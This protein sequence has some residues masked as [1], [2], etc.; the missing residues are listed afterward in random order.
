MHPYLGLKHKHV[1]RTE[2]EEASPLH[3]QPSDWMHFLDRTTFYAGII[4]PF[5]VVPQIW[6]IFTTH[7]AAGVSAVSWALIFIVTL[8]WVFYGIA[9]KDKTIIVSFVLWEAVNALVV[10]GALLYR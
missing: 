7:Q 1:R 2:S 5:M 9:H 6:Q 8:P 4:G 10:I 3:G